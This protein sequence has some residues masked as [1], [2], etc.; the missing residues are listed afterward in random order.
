M[1]LAVLCAVW[2]MQAQDAKQPY[3]RMAPMEQYRMDR[4]AEIAL[5][6]SAAPSIHIEGCR[7]PGAGTEKL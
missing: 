1:L 4:D 7:G 6:R 2:R 3:P 5:A